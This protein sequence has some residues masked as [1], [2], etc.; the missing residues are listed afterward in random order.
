MKRIYCSPIAPKV[1][2]IDGMTKH[3]VRWD[4]QQEQQDEELVCSCMAE[5]Y[6]TRPTIHD[7]KRTIYDWINQKATDAIVEGFVY[8]DVQIWLSNENQVNYS[9]VFSALAQNESILPVA[10]RGGSN[11]SPQTITFDT[12]AAFR[13]FW[14]AMRQH[15][16]NVV[17]AAWKEKDEYDFSPYEQALSAI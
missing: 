15:I 17:H 4:F 7:I 11:E 8:N 6:A 1:E 14:M 5:E 9:A 3:I 10:V 16:D 12:A 2:C 13:E